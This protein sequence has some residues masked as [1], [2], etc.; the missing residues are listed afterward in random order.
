MAIRLT[1]AEFRQAIKDRF[2]KDAS[3]PD[4]AFR[5]PMCK[6]ETK[7]QEWLDYGQKGEAMLGF[8][9]IGRLKGTDQGLETKNRTPTGCNYTNGGL[10]QLHSIEVHDPDDDHIH[11]F[12][13][14]AVD[15]LNTQEATN[16]P[17]RKKTKS[18]RTRPQTQAKTKRQKQSSKV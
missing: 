16:A 3:W 4:I 11:K 5:C 13:D 1:R 15:P 6:V 18:Q 12:F 14:F 8:S 17:D 2:G 7:G 10:F 9:C